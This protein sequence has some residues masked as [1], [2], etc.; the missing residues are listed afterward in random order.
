[1]YKQC[2]AAAPYDTDKE[3]ENDN[4]TDN[5]ETVTDVSETIN[6]YITN[7]EVAEETNNARQMNSLHQLGRLI[8]KRA[9]K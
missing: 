7:D 6:N 5:V 1:M 4:S 9:Q 3:E 2:A 8:L